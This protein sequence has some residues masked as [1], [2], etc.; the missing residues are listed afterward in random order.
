MICAR[1]R[2]FYD[3]LPSRAPGWI[4]LPALAL[5]AIL[6][7]TPALRIVAAAEDAIA[8]APPAAILKSA[9]ALAA[10]GGA[11]SL[12]G[13]TEVIS[14]QPDTLDATVGVPIPDIYFGV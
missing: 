6:Q 12:A 4:R 1:L 10:L 5:V 7:R 9:L 13:A 8:S 3:W 2:L 14:S 11:D